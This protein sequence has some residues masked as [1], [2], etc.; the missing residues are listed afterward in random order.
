MLQTGQ[1]RRNRTHH[2]ATPSGAAPKHEWKE[3]GDHRIPEQE[4]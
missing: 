1:V 4:E 2:W 3:A